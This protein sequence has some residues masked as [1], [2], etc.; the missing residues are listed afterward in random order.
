MIK[1]VLFDMGGVL[2]RFDGSWFLDHYNLTDEDRTLLMRVI[3]R[4]AEWVQIDRGTLTEA[5]GLALFQ[6]RLPEHLHGT[7]EELVMHWEQFRDDFSDIEELV[8]ELTER[9]W[10]LCLLSN[11]GLRHHEYWPTYPVSR[12]FGDRV[13]ISAD[14]KLLKP[15]A[16]YYH[17]ALRRL[18]LRAEECFFVDDSPA[19]IE[20][21]RRCG[22]D[23]VVYHGDCAELRRELASRGIL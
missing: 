15:E 19:N 17:E 5:E 9:G 4:S 13:V 14:L 16:E 1:H 21:A 18:G 10:E 8:R 11:A 12:Y 20:G 2:L 7:A 3:F 22:I 23:A 6:S